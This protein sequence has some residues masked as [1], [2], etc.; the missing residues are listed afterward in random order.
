[1][2][3]TT[4]VVLASL[5]PIEGVAGQIGASSTDG[6]AN[7]TLT[8]GSA[9]LRL[10]H[11]Y[12][13]PD[14]DANDSTREGY[15]ILV[16]DRPL[17]ASAI[18]LAASIWRDDANRQMLVLELSERKIRGVEVIVDADKQVR[19]T[20]AYSPDTVMGMMLLSATR[21]EPSTADANRI[22]GRLFTESPIQDGRINKTVQYDVK[23][24]AAISRSTG[25]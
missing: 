12:A 9:I 20:N 18:A 23:F 17:A 2:A 3:V 8:V 11:A 14:T 10:A 19:R 21:F 4:V 24:S 6:T 15:R 22:A 25:K 5:Q 7:G 16:T 1:M 13:F